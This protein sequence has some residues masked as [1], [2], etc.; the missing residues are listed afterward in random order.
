MLIWKN[1]EF[2]EMGVIVEKTPNISKANKK[3]TIYDVPGRN[4]FIS[5]DTD[6]YESFSLSV[7]CHLLENININEIC[8]WLDGYGTLS[9]DGIKQYTAIINNAIDFEK[10]Q[11]FKKFIIQ[12]LVNPI[13]EDITETTYTVS[14]SSDEFE[15]AT[16]SNIYPTLEISV[17]GLSTIAVNGTTFILSESGNYVLDCKNKV[18][19][20]NGLNASLNMNGDFPTLNK[21]NTITYSENVSSFV[22][23]YKKTYLYG[24]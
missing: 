15:I 14:S 1:K 17:S 12:F 18:I 20:K 16:Y 19:T 3:M 23:K 7:E 21:D 8:E 10:V 6:T 9:F 11:M 24:G 2:R 5:V 4:G 13:A 22:I